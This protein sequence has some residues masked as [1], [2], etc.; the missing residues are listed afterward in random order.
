ML[1]NL[2]VKYQ[3]RKKKNLTEN[4]KIKEENLS[5]HQKYFLQLG[6]IEVY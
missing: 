6:Y 2:F 5:D 4:H 3:R 1:L